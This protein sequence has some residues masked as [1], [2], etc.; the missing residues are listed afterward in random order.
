MNHRR[1]L[2]VLGL[3]ALPAITGCADIL[4]TVTERDASWRYIQSHSEG[5]TVGPVSVTQTE[6]SFPVHVSD[7]VNSSTCFHDARMRFADNRILVTVKQG[8]CSRGLQWP[9]VASLPKPAPG[10]YAVVYDDPSAD[11]PVIGKAHVE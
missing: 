10:E 6:L 8:F 3:L 7:I 9:F 5:M 2:S 11:F 4:A 1:P